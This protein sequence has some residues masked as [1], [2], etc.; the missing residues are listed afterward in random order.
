MTNS[1]S[2]YTRAGNV[3]LDASELLRDERQARRSPCDGAD[4]AVDEH[5][6]RSAR[7]WRRRRAT[8][9]ASSRAHS[10][11]RGI[12]RRRAARASGIVRNGPSGTNHERRRRGLLRARRSQRLDQPTGKAAAP[13]RDSASPNVDAF[14]RL[15]QQ[16]Q[17]RSSTPRGPTSAVNLVELVAAC[18]RAAQ[19]D[20]RTASDRSRARR[21]SAG[22]G[23]KTAGTAHWFSK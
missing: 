19:R 21:R 6:A 22:D 16:P 4:E 5:A 12:A 20:R 15:A 23:S 2:A 14:D 9:P 3:L 13:A 8:G 10:A 18:S 7:R 11:R 1:S 17:S